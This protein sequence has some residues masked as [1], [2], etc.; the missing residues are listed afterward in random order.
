MN[1]AKILEIMSDDAFI[2]NVEK[3]ETEEELNALLKE[4]NITVEDL[5]DI[6]LPVVEELNEEA[7]DEVSGGGITINLDKYVSGACK[8]VKYSI[9]I[10]RALY[11]YKKTGN[12]YKTY[13]SEAL[14]NAERFL[15]N[16]FCR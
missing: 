7:L 13:D 16:T 8:T 4:K 1:E 5:K 6:K 10:G 11:D 12:V 9:M 2:M 3:A 14:N 15:R